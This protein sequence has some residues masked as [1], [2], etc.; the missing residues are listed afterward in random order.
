MYLKLGSDLVVNADD[1]VGIFDFDNCTTGKRTLPL[2][3]RAQKAGIV[4]ALDP[5]DLPRSFIILQ[6]GQKER[7]ILSPTTAATLRRRLTE[8][9]YGI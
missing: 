7:L 9:D 1:I 6:H 8:E 4:E 3:S 5:Y 2:L